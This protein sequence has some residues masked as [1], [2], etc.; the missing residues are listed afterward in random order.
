MLQAVIN[1]DSLMCR[2]LCDKLH[3]GRSHLL[4]APQLQ[5]SIDSQIFVDNRDLCLPHLYS[6]PPLRVCPCRNIV[7]IFGKKWISHW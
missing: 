3:G 6:M 7:T 1:I 5:S 2:R 4:F